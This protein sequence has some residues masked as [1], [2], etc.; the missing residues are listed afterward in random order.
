MC[1]THNLDAVKLLVQNG[2]NV[3]FHNKFLSPLMCVVRNND[4][5]F[6]DCLDV[7]EFL[8]ENGADVNYCDVQ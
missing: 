1:A 2:A 7:A 4:C 8:I 3:N 5:A 6:A